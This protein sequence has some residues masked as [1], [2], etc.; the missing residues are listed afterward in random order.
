MLYWELI[1][2]S[3]TLYAQ[4]GRTRDLFVGFEKD[5][6]CVLS[7]GCVTTWSG[8]EESGLFL[9]DSTLKNRLFSKYAGA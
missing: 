2:Q 4:A 7:S 6:G 9:H 8:V 3:P 1:I 5:D